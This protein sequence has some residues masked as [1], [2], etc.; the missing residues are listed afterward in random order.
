[1]ATGTVLESFVPFT[2]RLPYRFFFWISIGVCLL[3]PFMINSGTRLMWIFHWM[4]YDKSM[5]GTCLS[6]IFHAY[7]YNNICPFSF[8]VNI[9]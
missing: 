7:I 8:Q 4:L 6:R 2:D 9:I 3:T 5:L 1:M